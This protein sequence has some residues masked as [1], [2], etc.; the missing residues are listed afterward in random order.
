[1]SRDTSRLI[2]GNL[3]PKDWAYYFDAKKGR[4]SFKVPFYEDHIAA[5]WNAVRWSTS[6]KVDLA[7][8]PLDHELAA[9]LLPR[10]KTF[11]TQV[12]DHLQEVLHRILESEE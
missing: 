3:D 10:L 4:Y 2:P 6:K 5:T 9:E 7:W 8:K 12:G 1:M 11:H